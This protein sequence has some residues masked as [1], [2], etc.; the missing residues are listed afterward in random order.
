VYF[1]GTI[2]GREST[3]NQQ[4][5]PPTAVL[6]EEQD[7]LTGWPNS[8]FRARRLDFH[9]CNE[10]VHLGFSRSKFRQHPTEPNRFLAKRRT[11]PVSA[12]GCRITFVEDQ[13]NHF[14]HRR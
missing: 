5:V 2:E 6:I 3:M 1:F 11:H 9:E 12:G 8:R 13:V 7:R 10:T 14:K 4:L